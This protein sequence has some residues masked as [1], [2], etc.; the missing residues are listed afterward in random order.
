MTGDPGCD[1]LYD[2]HDPLHSQLALYRPHHTMA[3]V[4]GRQIDTRFQ[5]T[6]ILNKSASESS[7]LY[8][9]CSS[10]LDKLLRIR[11]FTEHFPELVSVSDSTDP[12]TQ[13]WDI[14]STGTSLC[15]IFDQLPPE[16]GFKKLGNGNYTLTKRI[17][18]PNFDR[19][20]KHAI[21]LF[22]MQLSG[23]KLRQK[24]P[25]C[26]MFTVTDLWNRRSTD[27]LVKVCA[28]SRFH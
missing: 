23:Q 9:K 24:I 10:L 6:S 19:A 8:Q 5:N 7:S 28:R 12:V 21:A 13:I 11:G 17:Y 15:Y 1:A 27:G 25:E 3:S 20:K 18:E 2:R 16:D 14:L 26:E 4:A 22:A